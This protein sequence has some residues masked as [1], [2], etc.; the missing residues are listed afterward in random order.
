MN[1]TKI[2]VAGIGGVGGY[3]GG[4]L[5]NH[6]QHS[7]EVSVYFIAR[8][9]NLK[10]IQSHGLQVKKGDRSFIAQPK[11]TTDQ[12]SE[13]GIVDFIILSTKSYDLEAMIEQLH[14][15]IN[16]ETIILPLLNGVD[17]KEKIK[18]MLPENLIL[19]GCVYIVA[20]L[21]EPGL[22]ENKG[23]LQK[24]FFGLNKVVNEKLMAF[25]K[26][27]IAGGIEAT[28][29]PSISTITWEKFIFISPTASATSYFNSSIGTILNDPEK[30]KIIQKLI[31]EIK[32]IAKAKK[33]VVA[34]DISEK[35]V[36]ILRALPPETTSSMHSD[37]LNN[38]P[39][40]ELES[41]IG[42]V[43]KEGKKMNL[44]IPVYERVYAELKEQINAKSV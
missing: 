24:L 31:E 37:I 26:L 27:L 3:F 1:K 19:D 29:S 4:I 2:I 10:R 7:D 41:L 34:T 9:E 20:R 22:V 35:T 39:M 44:P 28:L 12:A 18:K 36:A 16:K 33:I 40:N 6:Y 5:A 17:S 30:F 8:G 32:L 42:Y 43:V 38:K 14:P 11:L 13:I 21:T 15:C 23:N 25:E